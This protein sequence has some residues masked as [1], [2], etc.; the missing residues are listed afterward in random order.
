MLQMQNQLFELK[1]EL[2][3]K[4]KFLDVTFNK[5]EPTRVN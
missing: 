3:K 5:S 2:N 4:P 1:K